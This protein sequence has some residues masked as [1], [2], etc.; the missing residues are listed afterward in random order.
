MSLPRLEFSAISHHAAKWPL[1]GRVLLGCA[2]AGLV[3]VVGDVLYLSSSR[4]RLQALEKQDM[5]LEQQRLEKVERVASLEART[6]SFEVTQ[7]RFAGLLRSLSVA[8]EVPAL[9]EDVA[10]LGAASGLAMDGIVL[11]DE[12]PRPLY[13]EQPLQMAVTGEYHDLATFLSAMAGLSRLVTVHEVALRTDG[14]LLRLDLMAKTYRRT[15]QGAQPDES[16]PPVEQGPRF[17][18]DSSGLRDPFRSPA[19]QTSHTRGRLALAPDLTRPRGVL[20]G[21]AVEQ[22]QM[23]GTLSR[24]VQKYAL[25]RATSAVYRLEVGDYLGPNH[26]RVTAIYDD[27]VE[28]VELFPDERGAWLERPQTLLLNVNS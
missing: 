21:L 2:L 14:E 8:S 13:I 7:Q 18:Y 22:F 1:P 4:E 23:V 9:L 3:L 20:E 19:L 11:L 25:L 15:S 17:V 12:Q 24:G 26:G 6:H 16:G 10:R 5:A 28:L 27:H